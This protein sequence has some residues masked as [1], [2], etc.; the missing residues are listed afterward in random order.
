MCA[1]KKYKLV[2]VS[3]LT[4][5]IS[6]CIY[7]SQPMK[8]L[9]SHKLI[10]TM[11]STVFV[12]VIVM[13]DISV[14]DSVVS[15]ACDVLINVS[16][17]DTEASCTDDELKHINVCDHVVSMNDINVIYTHIYGYTCIG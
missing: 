8:V 5:P 3:T 11:C 1:V 9:V 15:L 16:G 10:V 4:D 2:K 13:M 17:S 12:T 6:P 7:L 14:G